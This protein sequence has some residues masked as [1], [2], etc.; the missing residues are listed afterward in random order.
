MTVPVYLPL[1]VRRPP[2]DRDTRENPSVLSHP[3]PPNETGKREALMSS[4]RAATSVATRTRTVPDLKWPK[5]RSRSRWSSAGGYK[6]GNLRR[7]WKDSLALLKS[8]SQVS[9]SVEVALR[10][11]SLLSRVS[12]P[13][14]SLRNRLPFW[15]NGYALNHTSSK[16]TFSCTPLKSDLVPMDGH[17]VRR[18]RG[19]HFASAEMCRRWIQRST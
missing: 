19:D 12:S 14:A 15:R 16:Q 13:C 18:A 9:Q 8:P 4:P 3:P 17:R 1:R 6:A 10:S 2:V 7:F 5:A 11:R